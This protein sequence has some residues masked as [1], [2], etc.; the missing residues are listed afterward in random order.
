MQRAAI[1]SRRAL[2]PALLRR[3]WAYVVLVA[4]VLLLL[5]TR[6]TLDFA[7][8]FT[9]TVLACLGILWIELTRKQTAKEFP[10]AAGPAFLD[11]ART[12]VEG[13]RDSR[14]ASGD[15]PATAAP[16]DDVSAR[17]TNLADLHG[18]GA[19]TDEEYAAAKARVLADV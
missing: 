15:R 7:A 11:D 13:W 17:L 1:A 9:L 19:L 5:V 4:V 3:T 10:D 12:K 8:L 6:P 18:R 14:R 2:A 16:A